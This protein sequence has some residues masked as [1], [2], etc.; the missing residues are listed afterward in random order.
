[1]DTFICIFLVFISCFSSVASRPH[2]PTHNVRVHADADGLC[3]AAVEPHNYP[4]HEHKVTTNDGYILS[5]QNIPYGISGKTEGERQ[6]VLLQHGVLMDAAT[7]L[8][9]PP[10]QSLALV[11]ADE[12]F[13]VWLV[14]TRGTDYSRGHT[15]LSPDD[16]VYWDWSWDE[17]VAYDLPATFEYVHAQTGQKLHYVGHSQGTLMALAA[18]SS[19]DLVSMMRS[20]ALLSPI[21]YLGEVTSPLARIGAETLLGETLHWL[22]I[23]EFNPRGKA[24]IELLKYMCKEKGADCTDL[25][26]SFTGENCCLNSSIV[27]VFLQH[28]PQPTSTKNMI[29]LSQMIRG[30]KIC[31]YDYEDEEENKKHYGTP[32]PPSYEMSRIP[33]DLPLLLA[34]GGA[35][36]LSV[37]R[38]VELLL[39]SLDGH[40]R[41][42]LVVDYREDYAHA[43]YV[44]AVNARQVVYDPLIAFFRL[45]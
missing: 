36:A 42:K 32:A 37:A 16:A 34:Y 6:P 7:W 30:G 31:K 28:E 1:M 10:D 8:I 39:D 18:V 17:L 43:D 11:L 38:D 21:A 2:L 24:V 9:S 40:A 4:C 19:G 23:N 20:A 45:Q 27:S 14:S 13:D 12:G 44:M 35:D 15:S 22:H 5:L 33:S 25:L 26:T 41:D 29:H 3:S